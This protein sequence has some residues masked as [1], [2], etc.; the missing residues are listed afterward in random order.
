MLLHESPPQNKPLLN[1][2]SDLDLAKPQDAPRLVAPGVTLLRRVGTF[3]PRGWVPIARRGLSS[4]AARLPV[5][6]R[7]RLRRVFGR[8]RRDMRDIERDYPAWIDLYDRIDA[9]A[10]Q[11][12]TDQIARM[13]RPPLIS[14][15]MPT[16]NPAPHHLMA[17]IQS[18]QAQ[19]YPRWELC[20]AD[21][22]STD[23]AVATLLRDA[24][25]ADSRIRITW[26]ERNG[27]ISAAS[28]SALALATGEFVALL[29]HDDLLAPN[30]LYEVARHIADRPATDILY[31][32]EDHIDDKGRRSTPYFKPDW[33]PE[34][35]LGQNL[36][37][38]LGVYRRSLVEQL[39]GFRLGME[40]SQDYDLAV[41]ASAASS[42]DR[43]V[44][45]PRILYHWR[46]G[47][48]TRSF[49]ESAIDQ[50]AR[51]GRRA[52]LE[53][54][55]PSLP[56]VSVEP[57]PGVP[58]WSRVIYPIPQPE[59]LVSV[60]IPTRN[61]ADV[62]ARAIEGL[63]GRTDYLTLEVLIVDNGSDEP[64]ALAL[65]ARLEHDGRVRVLR[66]PGP[67][68]YSA[69]N[70]RAVAAATGDLILLMNNDLDVIN[71]DWLREMVSHAIRPGIGAVG[72]K[73]LYPDGTIQH[74][75][76][77][78]GVGGVA[79]HQYLRK[80]RGDLGYFGQ[81]RLVRAVTAVTGACLLLRREAYLEV[82]GLD[83]VSLPVAFNDIDLCLKL[84]AHGYRNLWTPYAELYHVESVSRGSDLVGKNAAR[85]A[86]DVAT[87][88]QRWGDVLDHDPYWNPNL[89]LD[90]AGISL[91]FP[92]RAA[93]KA[94]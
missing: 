58:T 71:P 60:I 62:L 14:V 26:R 91:A 33:N 68:N 72:A 30:A 65:L 52:V 16:F 29:D 27:H 83:E 32:D 25:A 12:M 45:I 3:V 54:L 89:S 67:F 40:G 70:N 81:L 79:G 13:D 93:L 87:M 80:P 77:T 46:Q 5:P 17:A 53:F 84:V 10:R 92:P 86:R 50:C 15:L 43:I 8:M 2:L 4:V 63:L 9:G 82:A 35:M 23:P 36:I 73:L 90:A 85:Y 88:R 31:S 74:G 75:G 18:V 6:L 37:N 57:A 41:R 34:L 59:P 42:P 55:A 19:I 24:Q 51:N 20:V 94:A 21:D 56:G 47:G 38:H 22:A 66:S 1:G 39:G 49:S 44:H 48:G 69:L 7:D 61:R 64:S 11:A 76:V 28:N 78:V